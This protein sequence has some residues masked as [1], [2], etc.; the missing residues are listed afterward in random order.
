M[1]VV[2]FTLFCSMIGLMT[3]AGVLRLGRALSDPPVPPD[4][5][6]AVDETQEY[7]SVRARD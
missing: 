7:M 3:L 2:S 4:E 5:P 6:Y 1:S